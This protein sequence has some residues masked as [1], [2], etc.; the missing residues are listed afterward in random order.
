M[1]TCGRCAARKSPTPKNCALLQSIKAGF[2]M[3]LVAVDIL[4]PLPM[5]KSGNVYILTVEDYFTRWMEVYPLPN[6]EA[7]QLRKAGRGILSP[8]FS[9]R[10]DTFRS[11]PTV[12]S[13]IM[14]EVCKLL[15]VNKTRT[16]PSS[17]GWL[18]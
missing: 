9:T 18:D 10:A 14:A 17:V 12:W 3:Q 2:P 13:H 7:V 1:R 15:G 6:Q 11:R 4:G 5:S 16:S 8:F